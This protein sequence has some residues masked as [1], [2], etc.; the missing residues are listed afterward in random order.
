MGRQLFSTLALSEMC[1]VWVEAL[2]VITYDRL[3]QHCVLASLVKLVAVLSGTGIHVSSGVT[4]IS[5][6]SLTALALDGVVEMSSS[7]T[8]Y[9]KINIVKKQTNKQIKIPFFHIVSLL[10]EQWI[11]WGVNWRIHVCRNKIKF[12][13]F[14]ILAKTFQTCIIASLSK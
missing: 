12:P 6:S 5:M 13:M 4:W 14:V 10:D 1:S 8:V 2:A 9:H 7:W 3:K 11:F